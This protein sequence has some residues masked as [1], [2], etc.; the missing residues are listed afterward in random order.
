MSVDSPEPGLKRPTRA[1][2]KAARDSPQPT[3]EDLAQLGIKVRDFGYESTLPAVKTVYRQPRQIQPSARARPVARQD[4]EPDE[5]GLSQSQQSDFASQP[6]QPRRENTEPCVEEDFVLERGFGR[7][8]GVSRPFNASAWQEEPTLS[9]PA[10]QPS[11]YVT[12]TINAPSL[13]GKERAISQTPLCFTSLGDERQDSEMLPVENDENMHSRISE[14]LPHLSSMV[15]E[16]PRKMPSPTFSMLFSLSPLTPL[17]SSPPRPVSPLHRYNSLKGSVSFNTHQ[18]QGN[19]KSSH[20]LAP[21]S[22]QTARP[23]YHLRQRTAVPSGN[24]PRTKTMQS[25]QKGAKRSR[26]VEAPVA[27]KARSKP[28]T[29]EEPQKKKKKTH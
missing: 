5:S 8:L 1:V 19:T 9:Q 25:A 2:L 12:T 14:I 20:T 18:P 16:P 10:H 15:I 7:R 11:Q 21:V 3:P 29:T 6:S 26:P 27:A 13:K 24:A 4:T 23:R 28:K 17:P 22:P